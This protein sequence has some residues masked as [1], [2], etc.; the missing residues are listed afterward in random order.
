MQGYEEDCWRCEHCGCLQPGRFSKARHERDCELLE[1][2]KETL[3][4]ST[5]W[6]RE[7]GHHV[8][9]TLEETFKG[10]TDD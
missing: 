7:G 1:A 5:R 2:Q 9:M 6:Q 10:F 3:R 8:P 4:K